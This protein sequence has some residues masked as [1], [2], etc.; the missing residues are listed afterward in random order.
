MQVVKKLT[1]VVWSREGCIG[2]FL[3]LMLLSSSPLLQM[4]VGPFT[5]VALLWGGVILIKDLFCGRA[6]YKNRFS[7]ILALFCC[8]YG[9]SI[10]LAG[11]G[12]LPAN[13]TQFCYMIL[14]FFLL[15]SNPLQDSVS[16]K[17]DEVWQLTN[18]MIAGM[19][20]MT[21]SCL[22]LYLF[23]IDYVY[24]TPAGEVMHTGIQFDRLWGLYNPNTGSTLCVLS[25]IL[26]IMQIQLRSC[27]K[28][29][30]TMYAANM[31]LQ[32][33]YLLLSQSRTARYALYIVL[34]VLIFLILALRLKNKG[35]HWLR[36]AIVSVLCPFV[37]IALLYATQPYIMKGLAVIPTAMQQQ[38]IFKPG[39][40]PQ[41]G[42]VLSEREDIVK[43]DG[44]VT[45]GRTDIWKAGYR[46]FKK[47]PV[48][49]VSREALSDQT[50]KYLDE[51]RQP[52]LVRGG[53]HNIYLSVLVC[54]GAAGFVIL[55][56]F[57]LK[58]AWLLFIKGHPKL[59][60][61]R[62]WQWTLVAIPVYFAIVEMFEA[63][64]LFKASIFSAM[65]WL[66]LGY[67]VFFAEKDLAKQ[68]KGIVGDGLL[69][70]SDWLSR[71]ERRLLQKKAWK[72]K[73]R[74][75]HV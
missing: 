25:I 23:M 12:Y 62:L 10:L 72:T 4:Y 49:G 45:N 5:K 68:G 47:Y 56:F 54:S 8:S 53:L 42:P 44:D 61:G 7:W 70:Q 40:T 16:K 67:A 21:L 9:I 38:T 26:S 31:V 75:E 33:I 52:N 48:F 22:I 19:A 51:D 29:L 55:G 34:A 73:E 15:F 3:L 46:T 74:M 39:G 58:A 59:H 71:L 36:T 24:I 63:R 32:Y 60:C 64:I 69:A 28:L 27:G 41:K 17:K 13:A 2:L 50:A 57:A 20:F 18:L 11:S 66:Y 37:V 30:K 65:F 35:W 14:I 1:N 43:E 6:L